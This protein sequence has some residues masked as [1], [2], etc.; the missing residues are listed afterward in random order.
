M[1]LKVHPNYFRLFSANVKVLGRQTLPYSLYDSFPA[2][3]SSTQQVTRKVLSCLQ[4]CP[5]G[6]PEVERKAS[7][8]IRNGTNCS[9]GVAG[10]EYT[11]HTFL[12]LQVWNQPLSNE[13]KMLGN[14]LRSAFFFFFPRCELVQFRF[15]CSYTH[16][17]V[18]LGEHL[19][20]VNKVLCH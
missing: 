8:W 16:R 9:A 15:T 7:E 19:E 1:V 3:P 17:L 11:S 18:S 13:T 10:Q 2:S 6:K 5:L 14:S 20:M 4:G 12:R